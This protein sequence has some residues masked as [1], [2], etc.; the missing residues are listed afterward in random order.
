MLCSLYGNTQSSMA[1]CL[2][3]AIWLC[4]SFKAALSEYQSGLPSGWLSICLWSIYHHMSLSARCKLLEPSSIMSWLN[5]LI[6]W[7]TT[8]TQCYQP[9]HAMEYLLNYIPAMVKAIAYRLLKIERDAYP[10]TFTRV[11][12]QHSIKQTIFALNV[13]QKK[14]IRANIWCCFYFNICTNP[15]YLKA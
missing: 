9:L 10:L 4:V 7:D 1:V 5:S 15:V 6:L 2:Q 3:F 14:C 13:L 12:K 8:G 11:I